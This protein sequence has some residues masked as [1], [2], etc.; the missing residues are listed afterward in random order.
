MFPVSA[1]GSA[2]IHEA[3]TI[4]A[5]NHGATALWVP[6]QQRCVYISSNPWSN[7]CNVSEVTG[8]VNQKLQKQ[9]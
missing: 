7:Q 1:G 9:Y 3:A 6:E 5:T 4:K 8:R 2:H